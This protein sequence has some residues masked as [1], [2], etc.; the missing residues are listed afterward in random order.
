MT[1]PVRKP[2]QSTWRLELDTE[3]GGALP[4]FLRIARAI[5]GDAR[6]GRLPP[7][8]RLPG[9]RELGRTLQL[10]RNTVLAAYREL[11]A[12]G[13]LDTHAGRG[14]F[15]APSLP[16]VRPKSAAVRDR[17]RVGKGATLAFDF[18]RSRTP[19]AYEVIPRGTFALYGGLPDARLVPRA[20]LARAYG[21]VVRSSHE[22]LG[23]GDPCGEPRLRE[24]IAEMLR[25]TRGL[26]VSAEEVL[27]T[28]GSQMALAL[29][30]EVLTRPG[31]VIAV[32]AL[33]YSPAWQA[34]SRRG[35][36][37]V[38]VPVDEQGLVTGALRELCEREPVRA[39]YV[40]PHHQYPSTVTLS[41]AR[42]MELLELARSK[43][44]ALIEDDYDHEFHYEGKPVLPLAS[45]DR[46]AVLYVGSL[47]KVLAPS[48]RVG[49][50]VAPAPV[51]DAAVAVRHFFDRQGD[52]ITENA[53]AEL[54]EDGELQ[55]HVWRT[56]RI[57][58][59]RRDHAVA[60]LGA[61][62]GDWLDLRVPPGGIA[63][64]AR[65]RPE[66]PVAA[67]HAE[68]VKRNVLFQPGQRFTFG[69]RALGNARFGFAGHTEREFSVAVARLREAALS[70]AKR[71]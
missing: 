56:R 26:A 23:Y 3:A 36:R 65:V 68:S 37:L 29:C 48:L 30:G 63:L 27:I 62:L 14:T 50:L 10:H 19:P 43:R 12:E 58:Q 35:A 16:E 38:P 18:E 67:W 71:S 21:R 51:R 9:S 69:G 52:R 25:T 8:T 17:Q 64:W 34:L 66:L 49:Y 44:F 61:Q 42:R 60:E 1:R 6:S 41:A 15:I 7:G 57:Y 11:A 53:L 70:V 47:S 22:V 13:F 20:T 28:R 59:A 39:A 45:V 46:G 55:R 32:E 54:M 24:A 2:K 5:A 31:D 40:T 33:G 4:A